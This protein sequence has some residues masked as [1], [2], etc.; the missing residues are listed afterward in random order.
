M[1]LDI[2]KA[3]NN[4]KNDLF[5]SDSFFSSLFL[6]F[7]N[8]LAY[9]SKAK[10]LEIKDLW[11]LPSKFRYSQNSKRFL[12]F[13]QKHKSKNPKKSLLLI[14]CLYVKIG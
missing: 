2:N 1:D 3:F 11:R 12:E 9:K 10:S 8:K 5:D 7:P 13:Y 6:L 14:L 4:S